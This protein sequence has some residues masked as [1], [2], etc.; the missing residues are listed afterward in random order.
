MVCGRINALP[1]SIKHIVVVTT[2]PVV[3]PKLP[4]SEA[5]FTAV[6][7]MPFLKG[8]LQK[9]GIGAGIV[10]KCA[11][12]PPYLTILEPSLPLSVSPLLLIQKR[13]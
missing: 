10:D 11:P 4:L 5:T 12:F 1:Q 8:A 6:D 7:N 3:F 13:S 2:V 9:T